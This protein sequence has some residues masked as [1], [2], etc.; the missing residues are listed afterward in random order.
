MGYGGALRQA[1]VRGASA[2]AGAASNP[3][4]LAAAPATFGASIWGPAAAAAISA[5]FSGG[6]EGGRASFD[7]ASNDD[8][9]PAMNRFTAPQNSLYN[10]I[11]A[12]SHLGMGASRQL[13]SPIASRLPNVGGGN[14]GRPSLR[15]AWEGMEGM[16]TSFGPG[17]GLTQFFESL[18]DPYTA[19]RQR[20][21]TL[22]SQVRPRSVYPGENVAG[23]NQPV[24]RRPR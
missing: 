10:A 8:L 2:A 19:T 1:G 17:G 24:R 5:L 14:S 7:P 3:L 23:G 9:N 15:S 22:T 11:R 21:S 20:N 13:D 18:I 4:A 16:N 6:G 12:I